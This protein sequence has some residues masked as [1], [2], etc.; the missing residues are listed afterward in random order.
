MSALTI[1][2][3][4]GTAWKHPLGLT[5]IMAGGAVGLLA[6]GATP[7][8]VTMAFFLSVLVAL[9]LIDFEQRI[10]PNAIVLPATVVLLAANIAFEPARTAEWIAAGAGAAVLL[11]VLHLVNPRG[12]GMGD[13]KLALLLGAAL[14]AGVMTALLVASLAVWPVAIY[15]LARRRNIRSAAIAFG[16][17]LAFGAFAAALIA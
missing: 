2:S 15:L 8:G 3:R 10:L 11:F 14:G 12:M 5:A 13:V 4:W 1:P 7:H 17:F 16:P 6:F 9:A